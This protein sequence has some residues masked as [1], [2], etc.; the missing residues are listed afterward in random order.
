MEKNL[1]AMTVFVIYEGDQ[2]L[3]TDSLRVKAVCNTFEDVVRLVRENNLVDSEEAL[4]IPIEADDAEHARNAVADLLEQELEQYR[5]T[6]IGDVRYMV[7]EVEL[8]EWA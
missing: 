5:Q 1:K 6:T 2:W 4:G 3:S 7:D 8:N